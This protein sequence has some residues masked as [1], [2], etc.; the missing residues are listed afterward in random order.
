[1]RLVSRMS[2]MGLCLEWTILK[3][4][5]R[6]SRLQERITA[7]RSGWL[8]RVLAGGVRRPTSEALPMTV[9]DG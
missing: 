1:M 2:W 8:A 4:W 3:L 9:V 5:I 7:E 6:E